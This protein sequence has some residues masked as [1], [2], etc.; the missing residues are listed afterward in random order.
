MFPRT[1]HQFDAIAFS[2]NLF[3]NAQ[4]NIMNRLSRIILCTV[5]MLTMATIQQTKKYSNRT[6]PR[7]MNL[8]WRKSTEKRE[9]K[10]WSFRWRTQCFA[11]D[12]FP[13]RYKK[14]MRIIPRIF[15]V[16]GLN[17]RPQIQRS[18][19]YIWT[20]YMWIE[21]AN[22]SVSNPFIIQMWFEWKW[23]RQIQ[24]CWRSNDDPWRTIFTKGKNAP[25]N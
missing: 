14:R 19:S 10:A 13:F 20:W 15:Q 9:I 25:I 7:K 24:N 6:W 11:T 16:Y 23:D 22:Y 8:I 18:C 5:P 1:C 21:R 4:Q 12:T 17:K 3:R 2:E